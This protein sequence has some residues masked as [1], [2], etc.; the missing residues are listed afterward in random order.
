MSK[1][2]RFSI[3]TSA[4]PAG[5]SGSIA[6][7]SPNPVGDWCLYEQVIQAQDPEILSI[8]KQV[9]RDIA[10]LV[11]IHTDTIAAQ[12]SSKFLLPVSNALAELDKI[13]KNLK[14]LAK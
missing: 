12:P 9:L 8:E 10:A 1:I 4:T 6:H 5:R 3:N 2:Q 7:L 14:E 11:R 13:A